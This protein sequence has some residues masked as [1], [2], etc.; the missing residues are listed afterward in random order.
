M[1]NYKIFLYSFAVLV[2]IILLFYFL[3]NIILPFF[4]GLIGAFMVDPLIKRLQKVIPNRKLAVTTFLTLAVTTLLSIILLFGVEIVDDAKRLN[5]A[6]QTFAQDHEQEINET[7]Q[8]IKNYIAK[9]YN[10]DQ[11][12]E[13]IVQAQQNQ[14]SL[15]NTA[16][17]HF[18]TALAGITSFLGPEDDTIDENAGA[19]LNWLV[20]LLGSLVYFFY[21]LYS[22]EYFEKGT[23][24][25]LAGDFKKHLFIQRFIADFRRIFLIYFRKRTKVVLICFLIFLSS[26][27][28]IDLPGAIIIA[29]I[30]ALL[31]YIPHFH[32]IALIP[33][34]LGCWV[35]S[36]ETGL[37]FY[38][39]LSIIAGVFVVVSIL[40]EL[41][42][43]PKIMNDFNGLNPAI[44]IVSFAVWSHLFGIFFGTLIALPLTT[45]VLIYLDQLLMHTRAV[46]TDH[47]NE[48]NTF[49]E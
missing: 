46:L 12:Q 20:V 49:K 42:F 44:M 34:S 15:Q 41:I 14:D 23:K 29:C 32:Y 30:T 38:I 24:K 22:F 17:E 13:G 4:V 28:I 1:T 6:F 36:E 48:S 39:F 21:V 25:Y 5:N 35:L 45:V 26:F 31:C 9:I 18:Q 33:I 40:E 8:N 7:N 43:T 27:L 10:A 19:N 11:V 37:S 2:V 16:L 47:P 3:G